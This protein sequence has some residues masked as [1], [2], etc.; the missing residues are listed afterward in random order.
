MLAVKR[1][2]QQNPLEE[3]RFQDR[4]RK[5]KAILDDRSQKIKD[6]QQI[7]RACDSVQMEAQSS[8][9]NQSYTGNKSGTDGT[10]RMSVAGHWLFSITSENASAM[11]RAGEMSS[12]PKNSHV[13]STPV[14][15]FGCVAHSLQLAVKFAID[16]CSEIKT[17]LTK[18]KALALEFSNKHYLNQILQKVQERAA[19][20]RTP[21][22]DKME[23][24]V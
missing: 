6:L 16:R 5:M 15:W 17:L 19:G 1:H 21:R 11:K 8:D 3:P 9:A 10:A 4:L 14:V 2:V 20:H 13:A 22:G 7:I 18:W 12:R 24:P 23:L